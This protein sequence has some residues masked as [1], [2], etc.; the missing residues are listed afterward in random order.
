MAYLN[1]VYI[2]YMV[3]RRQHTNNVG[4]G[5]YSILQNGGNLWNIQK[6][7]VLTKPNEKPYIVKLC[8]I[9]FR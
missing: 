1:S 9:N 3:F 6:Y 4:H 7:A 5:H 2:R 8:V